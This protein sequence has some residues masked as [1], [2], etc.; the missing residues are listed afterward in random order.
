MKVSNDTKSKK[1]RSRLSVVCKT[2]ST[3]NESNRRRS[4]RITGAGMFH[5][6]TAGEKEMRDNLR[7]EKNKN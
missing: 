3:G 7:K 2:V 6:D 1:R 4:S 5:Y